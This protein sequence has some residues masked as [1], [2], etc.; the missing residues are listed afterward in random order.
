MFVL[1]MTEGTAGEDDELKEEFKKLVQSE[2]GT[3]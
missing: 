2:L 1:V 3:W